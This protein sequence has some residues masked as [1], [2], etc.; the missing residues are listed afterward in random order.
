MARGIKQPLE[1]VREKVHTE[2]T[3]LAN[4]SSS[5]GGGMASEGY[6]GGY[7]DAIEDVTLALNGVRPSRRGWWNEEGGCE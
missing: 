2:I 1:K 5:F 4:A 6:K 7:L 3:D